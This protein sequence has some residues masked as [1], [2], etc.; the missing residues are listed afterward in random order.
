MKKNSF[1]FFKINILFFG[2]LL[3][4]FIFF[5]ESCNKDSIDN[6][7]NI[8]SNKLQSRE[9]ANYYAFTTTDVSLTNGMLYFKDTAVFKGVIESLLSLNKDSIFID[10]YLAELGLSRSDFLESEYPWN[11]AFQKFNERF[12][13][14][15]LGKA[16][17]QREKSFLKGGG[18]LLILMT[19]LLVVML[20]NTC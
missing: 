13:F 4:S 18:I 8:E 2:I 10:N 11:P 7:I 17:E 6:D 20:K 12:D 14:N 19:I 5:N 1:I 15:S 3:V 16:E 9:G